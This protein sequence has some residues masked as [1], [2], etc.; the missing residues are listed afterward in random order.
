MTNRTISYKSQE[1]GQALLLI[2]DKSGQV[3][4]ERLS[5]HCTIGRKY[6]NSPVDICLDSSIV[7]KKH[8]E[9]IR[10]RDGISYRD[11]ESRNGTY[12]NQ[13]LFRRDQPLGTPSIKLK[14]GD[15][16]RIDC[17]ENE[18]YREEAVTMV[19]TTDFNRDVVWKKRSLAGNVSEVSIG[20]TD[21][22]IK[23]NNEMV[24]QSHATVFKANKGWAIADQHS[25]N[26]IILNGIR[27]ERPQYLQK[28]DAFQLANLFFFFD[29]QNLIYPFSASGDN[30]VI[31]I[32]EKSVRQKMKKL[33]LLQDTNLTIQPG[34]MVLILGG[35]GAGKTTFMNAVMGYEKA[36]GKI[37]HGNVNIYTEYEKMKYEIGYV[38][39]QDLLRGSDTVFDTL[40]DAARMKMPKSTTKMERQ[41][42]VDEV[43][44]L[45]G[46]K[47]EQHSQVSKI[48]GGQRKRLSVAVELIADPSLLFLDEADSGLDGPNSESLMKNARTIANQGKIVMVITHAPD[49]VANLFDKV[50]VLAKSE[51]DHSG[52][53][54]F[55]GSI[56]DA[57]RFFDTKSL[58]DVVKRV[59][60][61]DEGGGEGKADYYIDKYKKMTKA[62]GR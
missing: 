20:R 47:A 35:S 9:F 56:G 44:E 40:N 13:T 58:E 62:G 38:P 39:Q 41:Q 49:R 25:T 17:K 5:N 46:L 51:R 29:G 53:L 22:D 60:R 50:V 59:N 18:Q 32:T 6:A 36:Q 28:G 21:T 61:K 3:Y 1:G 2:L 34:E 37:L 30:L 11:T 10:G 55:Y 23:L 14:N 26:G 12:L 31:Q 15:V 8:G 27:L 57:Y 7:S 24:S 16:L 43:L 42:R 19:F 52:H 45:V 54:A 33:T 48:S 4:A